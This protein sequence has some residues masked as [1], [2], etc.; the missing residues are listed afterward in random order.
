MTAIIE[1]RDE[2]VEENDDEDI[3]KRERWGGRGKKLPS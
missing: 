2:K 3:S 1:E